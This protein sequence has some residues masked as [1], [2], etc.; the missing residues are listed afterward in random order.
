MKKL[1]EIIDYFNQGLQKGDPNLCELNVRYMGAGN[2]EAHLRNIF[3]KGKEQVNCHASENGECGES[4]VTKLIDL[5]QNH[6]VFRL[7][8][9]GKKGEPDIPGLSLEKLSA[10][11]QNDVFNNEEHVS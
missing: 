4:A 7:P 5:L 8:T 1:S 6:R 11:V 10:P 2:W 3:L 9:R